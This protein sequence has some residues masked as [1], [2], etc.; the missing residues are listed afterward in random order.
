[1]FGS[2]EVEDVDII[3]IQEPPYSLFTHSST[4]PGEGFHL[5]FEGDKTTRTYFYVN[6]RL[7]VDS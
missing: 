3:A 1:M 4:N 6:R 2:E 5:A 7:D